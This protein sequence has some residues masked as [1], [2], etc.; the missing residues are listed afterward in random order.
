MRRSPHHPRTR[1][2]TL[3]PQP[4]ISFPCPS[5]ERILQIASYLPEA[6]TGIGPRPDDRA[7]W[8]PLLNSE[9]AQKNIARA[10][11]LMNSPRGELPDD[12]Y[13]EFLRTGNRSHYENAVGQVRGRLS[14]FALAEALEWKGRFLQPLIAELN[15]ILN[16]KS[17]VLPAHDQKLYN[18]NG[19]A[20]YPDLNSSA[21]CGALAMIDWWFQDRLGKDLRQRIRQ[22]ITRRAFNA[23]WHVIRTGEITYYMWWTVVSENWNSVCHDNIVLAALILLEDRE[24]RAEII[25][26]AENAMKLYAAGYGADGYCSEG[27]GYWNFGYG[28]FLYLAETVLNATGGR[29]NF[30]DNDRLRQTAGYGRDI[31][32]ETDCCPAFS[33][34]SPAAAPETNVSA[35]I[36]RHYPEKVYK[37]I[38][39]LTHPTLPFHV[40]ALRCFGDTDY[41]V[42]DS[43][44]YDL[45][46]RSFFGESGIYIGRAPNRFG[47][48]FKTG[49]NEENHNHNDVGSFCIVLRKHQYFLDPG[50]E[51]YTFRTF[52]EKRYEGQMLNSYGHMVP[53]VAGKLQ[54]TGPDSYGTFTSTEF[55]DDQDTLVADLSTA[56]K[57]TPC[58]LKLQRTFVYDRRNSTLTVRDEVT[59]DSPQT[60]ETALVSIDDIAI[61]G[62]TVTASDGNGGIRADISAEGG[63]VA[64][65]RGEVDNPG[66]TNPKRIAV[67]FTQPVVQ[68]AVTIV[69]SIAKDSCPDNN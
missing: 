30:F 13:L 35:F 44:N 1:M 22:E 37:V 41:P 54:T 26:A 3:Y 60:F 61:D 43:I 4:T 10:E 36:Q 49:N 33:D 19:T 39:P 66:Q 29:V 63:Q 69:F 21:V 12:L 25:A 2:P 52:S 5:R 50:H 55:T 8:L 68:A 6:P 45:P 53:V 18:F 17:W 24:T 58:L 20:P 51:Q 11:E 31:Q 67:A 9:E 16:E 28:H 59:F 15:A 48:A 62:M 64:L 65:L 23:Y 7:A 46:C 32:I 27:M 42:S 14:V 47:V 56:Y 34:C 57:D 38:P 40:M